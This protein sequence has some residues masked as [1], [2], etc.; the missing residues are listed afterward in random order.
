MEDKNLFPTDEG[1]PQGGVISPLLANIALHGIEN[2]LNDWVKTWKG[3]KKNNLAS[4]S[5]IRY[6]DDFVVIHESK[7]IVERA[8]EIIN[9]LL[10]P[11]ELQLKD[12][13]TKIVHTT[14]GFEFLGFNVRHYKVGKHNSGKSSNGKPL[15][16]K[17]LIK[18]SRKA[19]KKHYDKVAEVIR[20]NK[21]VSQENL[22]NL[23]NPVIRGWCSGV[24]EGRDTGI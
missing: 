23:L 22:I 21:S 2:E 16:F 3:K 8:K 5:F 11:I 14:E 15:G 7:A 19:I 24:R 10:E 1:T 20:N 12:E 17:T 18:P 4:F 9:S 13:K 6:A